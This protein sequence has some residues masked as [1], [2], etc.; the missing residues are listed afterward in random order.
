MF[1]SL[2][3]DLIITSLQHNISLETGVFWDAMLCGLIT[4]SLM[5]AAS[6]FRV[7]K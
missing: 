5:T 7:G 6:I 4:V 2:I 3:V 1:I